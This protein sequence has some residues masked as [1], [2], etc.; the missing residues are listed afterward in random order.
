MS[1]SIGFLDEPLSYPHDD[2]ATPEARGVLVLGDSKE[3]F[4]SSL[5]QWKKKDYELQWRQAV[6]ALLD[7]KD[8][9]ALITTYCG[10]EVATH[11]EWWPMYV[12]GKTIVIQDQL[13]FYDQ[14]IKPFSLQE[15]FSFLRDRR[16]ANAEGNKISEWIIG[17]PEVEEFG[18]ALF[19]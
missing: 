17:F 9:A 10:P 12:E 7:G 4:G 11:L 19:L 2:P 13:L 3:Y 5:Y 18:R 8:R 1:F 16:T 14:L 6:K 15:A